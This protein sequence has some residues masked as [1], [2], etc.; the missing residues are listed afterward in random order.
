[1]TPYII[2]DITKPQRF[3]STLSCVVCSSFL[4]QERATSTI[5]FRDTKNTNIYAF[6]GVCLFHTLHSHRLRNL[7]AI[8][9]LGL[10]LGELFIDQG[11]SHDNVL[12]IN[13]YIESLIFSPVMQ[14]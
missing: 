5:V 7:K 14:S 2:I 9:D 3:D 4:V 12:D 8:R 11:L 1:M 10:D 13:V 6:F